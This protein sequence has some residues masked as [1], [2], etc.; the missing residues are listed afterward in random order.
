MPELGSVLLVMALFHLS[1]LLLGTSE[2]ANTRF[3]HIGN[4][5][6]CQRENKHSF[7]VP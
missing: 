1:H 7:L 5:N 6:H 4:K 2:F 3:V